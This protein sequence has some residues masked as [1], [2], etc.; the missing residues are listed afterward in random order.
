[1]P[2]IV[3]KGVSVARKC[4]LEGANNFRN[5]RKANRWISGEAVVASSE[6]V[7]DPSDD[8]GRRPLV[9][10]RKVIMESMVER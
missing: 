7:S 1:M 2:R 10:D 9:G 6:K 4:K 5:N 8:R 3:V